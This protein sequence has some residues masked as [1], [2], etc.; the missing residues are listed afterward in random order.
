M[1]HSLVLAVRPLATLWSA[2]ELDFLSNCSVLAHNLVPH[3]V[4][5]SLKSILSLEVSD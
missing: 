3:S 2:L 4:A 1:R 5:S